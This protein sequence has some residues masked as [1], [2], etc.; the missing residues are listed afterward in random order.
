MSTMPDPTWHYNRNGTLEKLSTPSGTLDFDVSANQALHS[1]LSA[2]QFS[3][4]PEY[5]GDYGAADPSDWV[6]RDINW[7]QAQDDPPVLDIEQ[8]IGAA[9][10]A[11]YTVDTIEDRPARGQLLQ[12]IA[13]E[14][15][16]GV[17]NTFTKAHIRRMAE[18]HL[19]I[20]RLSGIEI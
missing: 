12:D 9:D 1:I 4:P 20:L 19:E 14:M 15:N 11:E 2:P 6:E 10:H 3:L 8:I 5:E 13:D 7:G 17:S 18:A 16:D